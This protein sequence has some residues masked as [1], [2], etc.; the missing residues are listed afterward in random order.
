M[1]K[2]RLGKGIIAIVLS[3][4]MALGIVPMDVFTFEA[5]AESGEQAVYELITE[6][7]TR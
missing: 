5:N 3:I 6:V 4:V 7:P 1:K 2:H